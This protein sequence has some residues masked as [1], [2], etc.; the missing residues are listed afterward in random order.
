MTDAVAGL[1][2][3]TRSLAQWCGVAVECALGST[4][5]PTW[6][7]LVLATFGRLLVERLGRSIRHILREEQK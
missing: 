7:R 4:V 2:S 1:E 5:A 6:L 3:S